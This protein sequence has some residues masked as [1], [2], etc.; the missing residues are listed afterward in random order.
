MNI[1]VFLD[2]RKLGDGGIG[3]YIENVVDGLLEF[4][5]E[6]SP[7]FEFTLLVPAHETCRGSET[8]CSALKR[9][10]RDVSVIHDSSPKY[11]VQEYLF[12]PL[13]HRKAISEHDIFHSPHYTLPYGVGIPRVVTIHDVI[14]LTHPDTF[15][16]RPLASV[17]IRSALKR[18]THAIT[19]SEASR[20][21]LEP[22][23]P[24]GGQL[25]VIPNALRQSM[26]QLEA[27]LQSSV[28]TYGLS[29]PYVLFIG[30]ER[31][32]KGLR[33]LL[34]AWA[35]VESDLK[36]PEGE[37]LQLRLVGPRFSPAAREFC[38]K[39]GLEKTVVFQEGASDTELKEL[40]RRARAVAV[41][42]DEEGFGMVAL[43]AMAASRPVVCTPV[44]SLREVCGDA[45]WVSA[46]FSA[47]SFA[48]ALKAALTDEGAASAKA[49]LGQERAQQFS[50]KLHAK[51]TAAVYAAASGRFVVD[52][53]RTRLGR[54]ASKR[55]AGHG[56]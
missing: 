11:S 28:R 41:P 26:A 23:L 17:L 38:R 24:Q 52:P 15:L 31:P 55:A 48:A 42:S 46:D 36:A 45:C 50:L 12:M 40:Y 54:E 34:E 13:R 1:R 5:A 4:S 21:R 29:H 51:R 35:L 27:A 37:R 2:A 53:Y 22:L 49:R 56:A 16:H 39:L 32:H 33:R 18:A 10:G 44:E 47:R 7:L 20:R 8:I 14:H 30:G 3:A 6:E 9:W 25:T 19:V 43:E